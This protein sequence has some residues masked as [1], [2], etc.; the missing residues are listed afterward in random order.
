M[1]VTRYHDRYTTCASC[2]GHAVAAVWIEGVKNPFAT[3]CARHLEL[4]KRRAAE[5]EIAR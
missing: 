2:R 3:T 1:T 4:W 5:A